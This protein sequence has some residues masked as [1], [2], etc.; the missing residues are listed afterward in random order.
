MTRDSQTIILE[1]ALEQ[2]RLEGVGSVSVRSVAA[3]AHYSPAGLYRH[4]E[5]IEKLSE[6]LADR[7]VNDY[8]AHVRAQL[9]LETPTA[10]RF[11]QATLAWIDENPNVS[12]LLLDC[13]PYRQAKQDN[14][15]VPLAGSD[16]T[17]NERLRFSIMGWEL[18][19]SLMRLRIVSPGFDFEGLYE[20][21]MEMLRQ[22]RR[23]DL[24]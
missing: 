24:L 13:D 7:V 23:D 2:V 14:T 1:A 12:Q 22:A 17:D 3:R 19:L 16:L 15:L 9:D 8:K 11:A 18:L 21:G 10:R 5:S 20:A 4:F 6:A